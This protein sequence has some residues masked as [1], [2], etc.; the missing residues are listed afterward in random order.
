MS[1]ASWGTALPIA[2]LEMATPIQKPAP[3][4]AEDGL[5]D[6]LIDTLRGAPA[7]VPALAALV[8]LVVWSTDQVGYQVT[9]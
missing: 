1:T 4:G 2:S 5:K 7:T 8:L 3:D 9:H 6:G